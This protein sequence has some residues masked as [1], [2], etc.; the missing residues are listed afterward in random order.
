[1]FSVNAIYENTHPE[2]ALYLY[3]MAPIS[4]A[5]LNPVAFI[6][7]E[8]NKQHENAQDTQLSTEN[9]K[10]DISKLKLL[11]QIAKG[12]L[13]NPVLVMTILGII[14]NI[15]FKHKISVYIEGL[16]EVCIMY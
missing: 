5:I 1:L 11:K 12:I 13:F 4:L 16:L 15:A 3:L 10:P 14:G 7:M 2:Y 9:R 6:L 8:I